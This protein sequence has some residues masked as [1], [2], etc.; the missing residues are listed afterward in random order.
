MQ[1]YISIYKLRD[2]GS[3]KKKRQEYL[4]LNFLRKKKEM[5]KN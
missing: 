3:N 1:T 5:K 4:F 2:L